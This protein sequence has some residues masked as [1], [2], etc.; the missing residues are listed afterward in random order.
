MCNE[1]T[2]CLPAGLLL[3]TA[4]PAAETA[5]AAE[6]GP[7]AAKIAAAGVNAAVETA[8]GVSAAAG[9]AAEKPNGLDQVLP[10]LQQQKGAGTGQIGDHLLQQRE[11]ACLLSL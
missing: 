6:A 7:A 11:V 4:D 2:L 8:A 3:V 10:Q 1:A 5:A 9:A